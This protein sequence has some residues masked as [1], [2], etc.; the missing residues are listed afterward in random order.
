VDDQLSRPRIGWIGAGRMGTE[1]VTRLLGGDWEVAVCNR[2]RAKAE[3]LADLGATVVDHPADLAGRDVVFCMVSASHDLQQV[4]LGEHGLL[5]AA[6][7]PKLVIDSSTVSAEASAEV[8]E[9]AASRGTAFLAAPVSGNPQVVRAGKL[10]F[11]VSGPKDA[12]ELAEPILRCLGQGA[13]YIGP[14]E[15]ARLVKIAHNVFLGVV[16]QS[17]AEIT[18][19]VEKSGTSRE[20]FLSF[21]NDS[22][23]GS[24]FSRY[25]TPALV[26]L[27]FQP[28]FTMPLLLKDFTLGLA[29]A[30]EL[31]VPMP[32]AMQASSIVAGA[33]GRGHLEEDFAALLLEQAAQAGMTLVPE[34]SVID[35]GLTGPA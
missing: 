6:G 35:D 16:I 17:L 24:M 33:V 15:A 11:A 9:A 10:T 27:D 13:T 21:L 19:L 32:L 12:F 7:S 8:R 29:A 3:P 26:N 5:T 30:Q 31:A 18:V 1:L 22:V 4:M 23:L 2:T 25:R 34:N 28:T 14:G 20:A